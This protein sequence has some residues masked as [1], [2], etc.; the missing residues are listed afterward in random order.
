MLEIYSIS[1]IW[2]SWLAKLIFT[3]STQKW[4]INECG[5]DISL[6]RE[7]KNQSWFPRKIGLSTSKFL[8]WDS[9]LRRRCLFATLANVNF[10]H[11]LIPLSVTDKLSAIF[12]YWGTLKLTNTHAL[13]YLLLQVNQLK[14]LMIWLSFGSSSL[15]HWLEE[16]KWLTQRNNRDNRLLKCDH[17]LQ[18]PVRDDATII[19]LVQG[20]HTFAS[21]TTL[22]ILKIILSHILP[23]RT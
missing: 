21:I 7:V 1:E 8:Q 2:Y 22:K 5:D 9:S 20:Y 16:W 4:K 11:S 14:W 13:C 10:Y 6:A 3:I 23:V 12:T 19:I 17:N 18:A 15:V